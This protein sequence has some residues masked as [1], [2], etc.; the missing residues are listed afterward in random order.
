MPFFSKYVQLHF[1]KTKSLQVPK[2]FPLKYEN[3][4]CK[5]GKRVLPFTFHE[6]WMREGRKAGA[7]EESREASMTIEAAICLP[8]FLF[9]AAALMQPLHWLNRQRQ[10]QTK[11]ESV[12]EGLAQYAYVEE[13]L[14]GRPEREEADWAEQEGLEET[15]GLY[16]MISETAGGLWLWKKLQAYTG[17][18]K[19]KKAEMQ[20]EDAN[21]LLT[22]EYQE[23]IPFFNGL[24]GGMEIHAAVKRRKWTGLDGKLKEAGAGEELQEEGAG[25]EWV[26]VGAGMGRYHLYRDCHYISNQY[27]AVSASEA[28]QMKN[29]YGTRL[30]P[31]NRCGAKGDNGIVY[32]TK[33]GEHYHSSKDCSAMAAYVR[34]V[35]KDEVEYLGVC[36]YCLRKKEAV[37]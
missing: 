6:K 2:K 36:S 12:C 34:K 11:L 7:A 25:T 32:I 37:Q 3:T 10:V 35:R 30:T 15:A 13:D 21:L 8:L 4:C 17:T 9:F 24:A 16:S 31:C 18:A 14:K 20:S 23:D 22:V 28:A 29:A 26:Y 33:A 1:K 5:S 27:E 19:M